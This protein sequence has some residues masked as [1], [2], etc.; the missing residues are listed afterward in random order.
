MKDIFMFRTLRRTLAFLLA[1]ILFICSGVVFGEEKWYPPTLSLTPPSEVPK[2]VGIDP[3]LSKSEQELQEQLFNMLD[4]W[5]YP[6]RPLLS[7][8][9]NSECSDKIKE[10]ARSRAK[11]WKYSQKRHRAFLRE[12]VTAQHGLIQQ[13]LSSDNPRS[14]YLI[15]RLLQEK[16][17][18]AIVLVDRDPWLW[19]ERS[20]AMA[21]PLAELE[22]ME[23]EQEGKTVREINWVKK[24]RLM[25]RAARAGSARAAYRL[26]EYY[27]L[28]VYGMG[29]KPG[30]TPLDE[31]LEV[32]LWHCFAADLGHVVAAERCGA[33]YHHG[34]GGIH[35]LTK[36][37]HYFDI[38]TR[39]QYGRAFLSLSRLY[40]RGD[41]EKDLPQAAQLRCM[42]DLYGGGALSAVDFR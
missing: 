19:I 36:A 14:W 17:L 13:M 33:N 16:A 5:Y 23:K 12:F 42:A 28:N 4:H 34:L 2:L 40:E 10:K 20:A 22:V 39:A 9:E 21:Y 31:R 24:L 7:R 35:D 18:S 1:Y 27:A 29:G 15:G 3:T 11:K 30:F 41:G 8:I 25:E 26:A 6:P 37:R 32:R 38:A